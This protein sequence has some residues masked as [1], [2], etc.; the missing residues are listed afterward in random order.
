MIIRGE[1]PISG[2]G[3][4]YTIPKGTTVRFKENV[5][6]AGYSPE[7]GLVFSDGASLIAQGTADDPVVFESHDRSALITF[8]ESSS[9]ESIIEYCDANNTVMKFENSITIQYCK[10]NYGGVLCSKGSNATIKNNSFFESSVAI[11]SNENTYI[12][13]PTIQYNNIDLNRLDSG[14]PYGI[15]IRN[16]SADTV[17]RFNN[18]MN[19]LAG[20]VDYAGEYI[21]V[22]KINIYDN[23]I[24]NCNSMTGVDTNGSQCYGVNVVSYST[25]QITE[26]GCGW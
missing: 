19:S 23:Y 2:E 26:A 13:C 21:T 12:P 11:D 1:K 5:I 24:L 16:G 9:T 3:K 6:L 22:D 14:D 17:I 10:F 8:R 7:P 25:S 18:I 4:T 20:A 15:L